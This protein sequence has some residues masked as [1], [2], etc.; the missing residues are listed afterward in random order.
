MLLAAPL[1]SRKN[2]YPKNIAN[3]AAPSI[4][5]I[6]PSIPKTRNA[7]KDIKE[8]IILSISSL[9]FTSDFTIIETTPRIRQRFVMQEP[10]I[11]PI[12]IS[13]KFIKLATR[14]SK[15]SGK[16]VAIANTIEPMTKADIPIDF[17]N[18][19]DEFTRKIDDTA[20]ITNEKI[21][22]IIANVRPI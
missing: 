10:I 14:T 22:V 18:R 19:K 1:L 21:I 15:N 5:E 12:P 20:S 4:L 9:V 8:R 13:A 7:N 11:T 6:N 2:T 3:I 17:E 16:L